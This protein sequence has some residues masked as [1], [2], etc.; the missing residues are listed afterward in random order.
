MARNKLMLN[1]EWESVFCGLPDE[2]AGQL[3]KAA[4]AV[5]SGKATRI[6][7][8]IL[9]AIFGMMET[10]ILK[11]REA[12]ESKCKQNAANG[13]KGGRPK[14]EEKRTVLEETETKRTV[15]EES[16]RVAKKANR[17]ERNIKEVNIKEKESKEREKPSGKPD[18]MP[19]VNEIVSYLNEKAGTK[20]RPYSR[21][22]AELIK[23]RLEE[24]YTVDDFKKV[25]DN[26]TAQ[27]KGDPKMEQYLRPE[28]LFKRSHFESYLNAKPKPANKF[29]NF[30]QRND[31]EHA[32]MVAK[33]IAMQ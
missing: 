25:I 31:A 27:W 8:P 30:P 22:T 14:S 21:A 17:I 24:R 32:D 3:I 4:F 10:V 2:Q 13:S 28:T 26:M 11:N 7:D 20:Y 6:T 5:H 29:Q 1:N 12:Y 9:A 18:L 15:T 23:G 33:I 16:E 19:S